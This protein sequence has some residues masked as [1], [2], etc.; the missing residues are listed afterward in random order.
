MNSEQAWSSLYVAL[1]AAAA[2]NDD[3]NGDDC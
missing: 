2:A 1:A 3:V